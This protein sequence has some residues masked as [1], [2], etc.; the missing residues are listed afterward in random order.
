[1]EPVSAAIALANIVPSL[2]RYFGAGEKSAAVAEKVVDIAKTITGTTTPEDAVK[3]IEA[4]A[5][6]QQQFRLAVLAA[7]TDLEKAYLADR[8]SA[9][10]R[11][12][13]LHKAGYLNRRA[14]VMVLMD[15]VGLIACLAAL[16]FMRADM[17]EAAVTLIST[18]ASYFGLCLRDA[19]QFEFGSSRGS[20]EKDQMLGTPK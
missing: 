4:S 2:M 14:D 17:G 5:E 13:E 3:A 15:V 11:D 9:R 1:M 20:R 6:L 16:V 10:A 7:D 8:Q 18:L 12:V 19:H